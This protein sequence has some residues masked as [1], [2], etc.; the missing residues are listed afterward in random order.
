MNYNNGDK[1]IVGQKI[2]F[3]FNLLYFILSKI[4][5]KSLQRSVTQT[6]EAITDVRYVCLE[7]LS[8]FECGLRV[9]RDVGY[10]IEPRNKM[11]CLSESF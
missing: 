8:T 4:V 6:Y 1:N 7:V 10:P 5:R 9:Q 2:I 11:K 3:I